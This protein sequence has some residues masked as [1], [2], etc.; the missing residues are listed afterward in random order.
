MKWGGALRSQDLAGGANFDG[1]ADG[2]RHRTVLRVDAVNAL[3]G[4]EHFL[5]SAK[6]IVDRNAADDQHASFQLN[7]AH[8]F[9]NQFAV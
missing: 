1:G 8:R 7:F 9:R 5:R 2:A 3:D 6:L 4:G